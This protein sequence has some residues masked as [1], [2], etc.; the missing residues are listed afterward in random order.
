MK[1]T[2]GLETV[3]HHIKGSVLAIGVFDGVHIGHRAVIDSVVRRARELKLKSV[4]VTFD[5]HPLKV[6]RPRPGVPSLIS[7]AHR[8]RL[9][10]ECGVDQL[11]VLR[12]TRS[13]SNL[14]AEKFVRDILMKTLGMR[15]I[16]VGENFYF[17]KGGK[18]GIENLRSLA[19]KAG[20]TIN[21]VKPVKAGGLAVSSSRIR[22]AVI[23]GN[24]R[25]ASRLLGRPVSILGG[26]VRGAKLAR[27]LG[28]PTANINPHHEVIPPSGV[29]AVKVRFGGRLFGGIL[30]I[31]T[32]PTFYG[33]GDS[34]PTIEVHIFGFDGKIY[35]KEIEVF[36]VN[37][38]RRESKFK[39]VNELVAQIKRDETSARAVLGRG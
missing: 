11:V 38:L 20:F 31:G 17:G 30:N 24:L 12:F 37:R 13:F 10:K 19:L 5:P 26:V 39:N 23:D 16:Y 32:R 29:Y 3:K 14:P 1:I 27:Q 15:E 21:V 33:P 22:K 6:L 35:G 8:I 9:I 28:Y 18:S 34:E 36:F 4:V 7:L 2:G 25:A